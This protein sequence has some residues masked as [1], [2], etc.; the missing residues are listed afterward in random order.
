[1]DEYPFQTY[2]ISPDGLWA[3]VRDIARNPRRGYAYALPK[4]V[5][6][7]CSGAIDD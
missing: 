7:A 2:V 1:V 3:A 6:N 4:R 5:K